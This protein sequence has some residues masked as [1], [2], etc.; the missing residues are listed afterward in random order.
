[1]RRAAW[2]SH[3]RDRRKQHLV[4]EPEH[5]GRRADSE[6]ESRDHQETES[7]TPQERALRTV[8]IGEEIDRHGVLSRSEETKAG[9]FRPFSR[10]A[11]R[12]KTRAVAPCQRKARAALARISILLR[13]NSIRWTPLA[14]RST[15]SVRFRDSRSRRRT[16]FALL[17]LFA[18]ELFRTA[19]ATRC[20][21]RCRSPTAYLHRVRIRR[22]P[23]RRARRSGPAAPIPVTAARHELEPKRR[24]QGIGNPDGLSAQ[25]GPPGRIREGA[26][27]AKRICRCEGICL[28]LRSEVTGIASAGPARR[29]IS[30]GAR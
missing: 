26:E 12:L 2:V 28:G 14:C 30:S 8:Q 1:M 20:L 3:A 18:M 11:S 15:N 5:H 10:E 29:A 24:S 22:E 25:I 21:R 27:V 16:P 23:A 17:A 13:H 7:R 9:S 4:G 19:L 6:A